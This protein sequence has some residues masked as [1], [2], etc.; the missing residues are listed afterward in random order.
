MRFV[1]LAAIAVCVSVAAC[2]G[3][4][5][6]QANSAQGNISKDSRPP[7]TAKA[8][9]IVPA[10]GATNAMVMLAVPLSRDRALQIMKTRHDGMEAIGDAFKAIHRALGGTPDVPTVRTNAAKIA[11]LS[12]KAS[13]WFPAGTGPD[14]AKT[15]AKPEVWQTPDDFAAKLRGFQ[16]AARAFNAAAA[17]NDVAAMNARFN[18]LGGACKA[19][20]DKYRAE[21]QH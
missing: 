20:H 6:G 21:E 12:Q 7:A 18:D 17:G 4:K 1:P 10:N 9:A 2:G 3:W 8:S 5:S 11:Q 15:R 16:G 19:C 14:V 13:G